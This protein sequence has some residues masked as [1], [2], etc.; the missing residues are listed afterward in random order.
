MMETQQKITV[1]IFKVAN[2]KASAHYFVDDTTVVHSVP[3]RSCCLGCW[4]KT[5][6]TMAVAGC[7]ESAKNANTLNVELCDTIKNGTVKATEATINNALNLVKGLMSKYNIPVDRVIRHYDVNGK[8][9][10]VLLGG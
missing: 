1:N 9:C 5:S 2:R 3:R 10:P 4:R 6:T 8:P 7:T